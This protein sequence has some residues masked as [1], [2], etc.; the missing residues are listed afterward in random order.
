MTLTALYFQIAGRPIPLQRHRD[1]VC[2]YKDVQNKKFNVRHWKYN[3]QF[4]QM[5]EVRDY[6]RSQFQ[7]APL[8]EPLLVSYIFSFPIPKGWNKKNHALAAEQKIHHLGRPDTSNLIKFYEDCM[9]EVVYEDDSQ[10]IGTEAYKIYS[11]N[12]KT[13]IW[14]RTA[15]K[16][17]IE[18]K[19]SE[20][21]KYY[22]NIT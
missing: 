14:M 9:N 5:E 8:S 17:E 1:G 16:Q 2:W 22:G 20:I 11:E 15:L 3:P 10:I 12:P 7:Y 13:Q 19:L 18:Q 6:F 21:P 4:K